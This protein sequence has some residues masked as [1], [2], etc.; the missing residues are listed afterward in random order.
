MASGNRVVVLPD[1]QS[2]TLSEAEAGAGV[3]C[4]HRRWDEVAARS[5]SRLPARHRPRTH[6]PYRIPSHVA[7]EIPQAAEPLSPDCRQGDVRV[8]AYRYRYRAVSSLSLHRT[9]PQT[10]SPTLAGSNFVYRRRTRL[11]TD[12]THRGGT[13]GGN[14]GKCRERWQCRISGAVRRSPS[15]P[16]DH[17]VAGLDDCLDVV[18][19]GEVETGSGGT[20]YRRRHG[21]PV[22]QLDDNLGHDVVTGYRSDCTGDAG[23]CTQCHSHTRRCDTVALS[24]R[25]GRWATVQ[26]VCTV[27]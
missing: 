1:C 22:W 7:G 19:L 27:G 13:K 3:G 5:R 23:A 6:P 25:L 21:L 2:H 8:T 11:R 15:L 16:S 9:H 26:C 24:V 18:T 10:M 4:D 17:H 20:R 14:S 12:S